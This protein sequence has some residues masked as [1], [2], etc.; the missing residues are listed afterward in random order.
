MLLL[1]LGLVVF[2]GIHS[3]RVVAPAY[4]ETIIASR[5][6]GFWKGTYSLLSIV[7]FIALIY[8][9][10]LAR[11]DAEQLFEPP[12][13]GRTLLLIAMPFVLIILISSQLPAGY[14]KR[15]LKHPMTIAV[16]V[17][18]LLH[19]IANGDSASALL[20]TAFLVWSAATLWSGFR[21]PASVVGQAAIWPDIASV[22]IGLALTWMFIS[23]LHEWLIGVGIV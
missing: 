5:G 17:W 9:Y 4:R 13:W 7:G 8:G 18:S 14:L 15:A 22:T 1:I 6:D 10:G 2:I 12:L 11:D 23:F 21:R 19:L 3:V 20:F 16:F